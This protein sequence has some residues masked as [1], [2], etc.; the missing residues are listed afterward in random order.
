MLSLYKD[1]EIEGLS[2]SCFLFEPIWKDAFT[3]S[4]AFFIFPWENWESLLNTGYLFYLLYFSVS[5]NTIT[6]KRPIYVNIIRFW[7]DDRSV[8]VFV[9]FPVTG[10]GRGRVWFVH[11]VLTNQSKRIFLSTNQEQ[12][13]SL[14]WLGERT[15]SRAY[16]RLRVFALNY[17]WPIAFFAVVVIG[18]MG[19]LWFRFH[20][21]QST[22]KSLKDEI[23]ENMYQKKQRIDKWL[24]FF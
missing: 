1:N 22:R 15:F 18:Q 17:D 14:P 9:C 10:G 19:L 16:H 24:I 11:L 23:Y 12:T 5:I 13:L 8:R 21:K 7:L 6:F 2:I 3:L 20:D 4:F